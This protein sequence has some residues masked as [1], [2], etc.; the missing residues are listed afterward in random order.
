MQNS[1]GIEVTSHADLEKVHVDFYSKLF[2]PED[3]DMACQHHLFSQLN[4]QLSIDESASCEG[5]ISLQEILDSIQSL[6]RWVHFR[7]LPLFPA[8]ISTS[9]VSSV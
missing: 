7:I 3:V 5:P 2:S 9:V 4:V 8:F 1:S 6:A